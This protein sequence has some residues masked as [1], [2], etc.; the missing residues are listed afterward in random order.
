MKRVV[1]YA[2][3]IVLI[4]ASPTDAVA[5][6]FVCYAMTRGESAAHAAR[7]VTGTGQN[8]RISSGSRLWTARHGS[9]PSRSTTVLLVPASAP[10]SSSRPSGAC[11][12]TRI[13]SKNA[14]PPPY[15]P[16][17]RAPRLPTEGRNS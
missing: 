7:R 3:L 2:L 4:E 9:F 12:R 8:T 17:P 6:S 14:K 16:F 10:V 11:L 15:P 5:Q 13:T 1:W